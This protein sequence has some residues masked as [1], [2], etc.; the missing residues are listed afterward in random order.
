MVVTKSHDNFKFLKLSHDSVS[1]DSVNNY[2][3]PVTHH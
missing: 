2:M 1:R 3:L